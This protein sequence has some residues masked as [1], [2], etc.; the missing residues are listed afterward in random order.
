MLQSHACQCLHYVHRG[1][2]CAIPQ[3]AIDW[4][5][6]EAA[7][8]LHSQLASLAQNTVLSAGAKVPTPKE[9]FI[10]CKAVGQREASMMQQTNINTDSC[11][12]TV[13]MQA[14]P[15]RSNSTLM[16]Y[17]GGAA[18]YPATHLLLCHLVTGCQDQVFPQPLVCNP[19]NIRPDDHRQRPSRSRAMLRKTSVLCQ[20]LLLLS[21]K[22]ASLSLL[23][24]LKN[25]LF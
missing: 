23:G 22:I 8:P 11:A 24:R 20:H 25:A 3:R 19:C 13:H 2:W 6:A 16:Q 17:A 12:S 10:L 7:W 18:D 15:P 21:A 14:V 5:H 1:L 4:A 9:C